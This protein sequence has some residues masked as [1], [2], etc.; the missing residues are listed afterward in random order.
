MRILWYCRR[1]QMLL[2][3][4]VKPDGGSNS[5]ILR[6][7]GPA[8]SSENNMCPRKGPPNKVSDRERMTLVILCVSRSFRKIS[9]YYIN[10]IGP[11]KLPN[12][13]DIDVTSMDNSITKK[14]GVPRTYI[15]SVLR[16][17]VKGGYL[18]I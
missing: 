8:F 13:V 3:P 4:H 15:G 10:Q 1:Q 16:Q 5:E 14:G 18:T 6:Y 7:P 11:T 17:A 2:I 12:G 9:G